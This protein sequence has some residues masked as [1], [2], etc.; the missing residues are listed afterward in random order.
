MGDNQHGFKKNP[1]TSTLSA[2]VQSLI[3]HAMDDECA[4]LAGLNLGTAFDLVNVDLLLKMTK[5]YQI[6]S[7]CH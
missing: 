6:T 1:S 5:N 7:G 2:K 4:L 3:L